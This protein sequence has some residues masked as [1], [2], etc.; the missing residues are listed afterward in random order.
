MSRSLSQDTPGEL[1]PRTGR[2]C[3]TTGVGGTFSYPCLDSRPLTGPSAPPF[4]GKCIRN[5]SQIHWEGPNAHSS[6]PAHTEVSCA[7][8]GSSVSA[9]LLQPEFTST[10]LPREILTEPQ[11]AGVSI[12][13]TSWLAPGCFPRIHSSP[14]RATGGKMPSHNHE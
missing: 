11:N 2:L 13:T 8:K 9:A 3:C 6:S 1:W 5:T 7:H 14:T 4:T 12:P 10:E